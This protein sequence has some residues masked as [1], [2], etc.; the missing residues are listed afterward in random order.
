MKLMIELPDDVYNFIIQR[1]HLPHAVNI[2]GSIID[3][4]VVEEESEREAKS[5]EKEGVWLCTFHSTFPQY[6]PDEY[7]CSICNGLGDKSDKFCNRCG[8]RMKT[9]E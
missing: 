5:E 1:G 3:G 2:A 4:E 7:R 6:E 8:A 9:E